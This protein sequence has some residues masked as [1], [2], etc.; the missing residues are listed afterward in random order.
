M[1]VALL[2]ATGTIGSAV[3]RQAITSG[4]E[5]RALVRTAGS[6]EPAPGCSVVLGDARDLTAVA[7]VV[8]GSDAVISAIGPRGNTPDAVALLDLVARNV[9]TAMGEKGVSRLVFV[10]GAGIALAGERRSFSQRVAGFLVRRL[11]KWV[12]LSKEREMEIYLA[13]RLKWT[14][15]RPTRVIAGPATGFVRLDDRP[16]GFR[17]TSGDVAEAILKVLTDPAAEG[18]APFVSSGASASSQRGRGREDL[19]RRAGRAAGRGSHRVR[20]GCR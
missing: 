18:T 13:S 6:L 4:H 19:S 12:V 2:G 10:A 14:A 11:A 5:V 15:M 1:R 7:E 3:L 17:V 20:D 9:V 8:A 16:V